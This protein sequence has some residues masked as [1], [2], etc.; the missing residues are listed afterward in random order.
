VYQ[1]N[2]NAG[3]DDHTVCYNGARNDFGKG[4]LE[5]CLEMERV[6]DGPQFRARI[7]KGGADDL[8]SSDVAM[9]IRGTNP[10]YGHRRLYYTAREDLDGARCSDWHALDVEYIE[11]AGGDSDS[12]VGTVVSPHTALERGSAPIAEIVGQ[13]L[14]FETGW[15]GISRVCE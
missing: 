10:D 11:G 3:R 15:L 9:E 8:F 6:G 4:I 2:A 14:H 5:L 1:F 7:C 13:G 12:L